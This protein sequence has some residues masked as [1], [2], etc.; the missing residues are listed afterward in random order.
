MVLIIKL[1]N[2][3]PLVSWY[4]VTYLGRLV[5]DIG[6]GHLGRPVKVVWALSLG[7]WLGLLGLGRGW[8]G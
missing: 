6:G 3:A 5:K 4:L 8:W 2:H 7:L 1:R